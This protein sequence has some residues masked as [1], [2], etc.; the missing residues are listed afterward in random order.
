MI[1]T[2][3]IILLN[4]IITGDTRF[5]E[6]IYSEIEKVKKR[7]AEIKY[8]SKIDYKEPIVY[9][10]KNN[11]EFWNKTWI[12]PSRGGVYVN[13]TIYLIPVEKLITTKSMYIVRH[14]YIHHIFSKFNFKLWVDEGL[15]VV[16][17]GPV[18]KLYPYFK[19]KEIATKISSVSKDT[20][21]MVYSSAA[22]Y[23]KKEI[24]KYGFENFIKIYRR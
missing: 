3:V 5:S 10:C 16:Y 1:T 8:I 14:E 12:S 7:L 19:K 20:L 24:K 15:A 21:N 9:I 6:N 17:G 2:F 18:I 23:V 11:K 13:D 22:Y 4:T